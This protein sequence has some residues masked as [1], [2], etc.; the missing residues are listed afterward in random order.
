MRKRARFY[1]LP[2]RR[3]ATED[4]LCGDEKTKEWGAASSSLLTKENLALLN[5]SVALVVIESA[6]CCLHF[7]SFWNDGCVPCFF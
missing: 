2:E 3:R 1:F 5:Y 4:S 6:E 7:S